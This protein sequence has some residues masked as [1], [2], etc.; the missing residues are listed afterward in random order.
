MQNN[1]LKAGTGTWS[2]SLRDDECWSSED[3]LPTRSSRQQQN[4][5][6][7]EADGLSEEVDTEDWPDLWSS[8]SEGWSDPIDIGAIDEPDALKFV[9]T[10]FTI[11]KR[12]GT[13]WAKGKGREK[14][15]PPASLAPRSK[16]AALHLQPSQLSTASARP[17]A[18]PNA[19]SASVASSPAQSAPPCTR[20]SGH[21]PSTTSASK[22]ASTK[23][24]I[25]P[26]CLHTRLPALASKAPASHSI[27]RPALLATPKTP[28]KAPRPFS[29]PKGAR[30]P[31]PRPAPLVIELD[32]DDEDLE[33]SSATDSLVS[34]GANATSETA[35]TCSLPPSPSPPQRS[36]ITIRPDSARPSPQRPDHPVAQLTTSLSQP[37][38]S[39][40]RTPAAEV[41][42]L[43][44][45]QVAG[46]PHAPQGNASRA[47][48][49]PHIRR[50]AQPTPSTKSTAS[51][52]SPPSATSAQ[53]LDK[54]RHRS[55][56]KTL[57]QHLSA[58]PSSL[59]APLSS[60]APPRSPTSSA[61]T[62]PA[63][64]RSFASSKPGSTATPEPQVQTSSS[65]GR[66]TLPG[67]TPSGGKKS[68]KPAESLVAFRQRVDASRGNK[69]L[70]DDA[71]EEGRE[72]V[73]LGA[74]LRSVR[75]PS[76]TSTASSSSSF[77]TRN[78][79]KPRISNIPIVMPRPS[80]PGRNEG[81]EE[82]PEER[83]R[84]IYR[85][86]DG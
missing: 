2:R 11:A 6:G 59:S 10:P 55:Q 80:A 46:S 35:P 33:A 25:P 5:Q 51:A 53:K 3:E 48:P 60:Q 16:K 31:E 69:H 58:A 75:P 9:E 34:R 44:S 24:S 45:R 4:R 74:S 23:P 21:P 39:L 40:V 67:L 41:V 71:S 54:F 49:L 8:R 79:K 1:D 73:V 27:S 64:T 84:R 61:N 26:T 76:S 42:Q 7:G 65:T 77:G 17:A 78:R 57:H 81:H 20:A 85:S 12:T 32:D 43:D 83:L 68:F 29:A 86:L 18:P 70:R 66:F 62:V 15:A 22:L 47:L 13:S 82:T 52:A 56:S 30:A 50:P 14:P 72:K 38:V 19:V 63:L 28:C 36:E 37:S